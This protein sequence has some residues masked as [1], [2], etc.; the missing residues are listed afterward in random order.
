M[1]KKFFS[2][3]GFHVFSAGDGAQGYE[4]AVKEKPDLVITDLLIPKIHGLD[5]CRKIKNDPQLGQIKVILLTAVYKKIPFRDDIE[6]CGAED[7]LEKPVDLKHLKNRVD[8]LLSMKR[9]KDTAPDF[10]EVD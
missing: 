6:G 3:Q 9:E 7:Y 1:L 10:Y 5:L 2:K 4:L 8:E